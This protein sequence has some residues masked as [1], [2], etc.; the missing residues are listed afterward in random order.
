MAGGGTV[1]GGAGLAAGGGGAGGFSA[2]GGSLRLQDTM[3]TADRVIRVEERVADR[4][5]RVVIMN[6]DGTGIS[7]IF[8][9]S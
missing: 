6:R 8:S 4:A 3:V 1:T 7:A 5:V 9:F 2:G